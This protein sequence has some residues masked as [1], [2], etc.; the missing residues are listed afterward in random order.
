MK[1]K[2]KSGGGNFEACPAGNHPAVLVAIID[3]G[4]QKETFN[5]EVK[6][7]RKG[8]FC[9]Y[10][11]ENVTDDN[12]EYYVG[13]EYTLSF[14]E[15]AGLRKL[16][17]SWRNKPFAENEEFDLKKLLGQACLLNVVNESKKDKTY[18]KI[19]GVSSLPKGMQKPSATVEAV[20][21]D[22]D[23]DSKDNF[24]E[25]EWLPWSYGSKLIDIAKRSPEWQWPAEKRVPETVPP[26][27][28]ADEDTPF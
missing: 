17:E 22:F 7:A 28:E 24:P 26:S 15:K 2:A 25:E 27:D 10:I 23:E 6:E 21:F 4:T 5:G 20:F 13:R 8:Y 19:A 12:K 14:H 18:S 1:M 3:L 11:P 9:W 16:V